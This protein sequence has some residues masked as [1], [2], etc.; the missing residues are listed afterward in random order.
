MP[1][2]ISPPPTTPTFLIAIDPFSSIRM[3]I[4]AQLSRGNPPGIV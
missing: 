1:L 4:D 3:L 2:P